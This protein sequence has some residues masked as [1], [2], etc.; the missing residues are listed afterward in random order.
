MN[1]SMPAANRVSGDILSGAA[2]FRSTSSNVADPT[3][4]GTVYA[5]LVTP[6]MP[7]APGMNTGTGS[8]SGNA[9][10]TTTSGGAASSVVVVPMSP[11]GER[12]TLTTP[13]VP[14]AA[15]GGTSGAAGGVLVIPTSPD[16]ERIALTT[17]G[18]GVVNNSSSGSALTSPNALVAVPNAQVITVS[19]GPNAA[20]NAAAGSSS[21]GGGNSIANMTLNTG[22]ASVDV[23]VPGSGAAAISSTTALDLPLFPDALNGSTVGG[24]SSNVAAPVGSGAPIGTTAPALSGAAGS[25]NSSSSSGG[26][27]GSFVAVLVGTDTVAPVANATSGVNSSGGATAVAGGGPVL[28][29]T[30]NA[31]AMGAGTMT[32]IPSS[33]STID[34]GVVSLGN[35]TAGAATGNETVGALNVRLNAT[36]PVY[37]TTRS[38]TSSWVQN[39]TATMVPMPTPW[40]SSTTSVWLTAPSAKAVAF[41]NPTITAVSLTNPADT[42]V[43]RPWTV[44]DAPITKALEVPQMSPAPATRPA[45]V[46]L[47]DLAINGT[48]GN[49][50]G[51]GNM[52]IGGQNMTMTRPAGGNITI[53]NV[54]LPLSN[55]SSNATANFKT[56]RANNVTFRFNEADLQFLKLG[57]EPTTIQRR[58]GEGTETLRDMFH[59]QFGLAGLVQ[60]AEIAWQQVSHCPRS[61]HF[62]LF[63]CQQYV[64]MKSSVR[65]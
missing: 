65:P 3:G 40:D 28:P 32:P 51:S 56:I 18:A 15:G 39:T 21:G 49:G 57:E 12:I 10:G 54:T 43:D 8:S 22:G 53:G 29:S 2:D 46:I 42:A 62:T 50:T 35:A 38:N 27:S 61:L 14:N 41:T 1:P 34:L 4:G 11:D 25:V 9:I 47:D 31:A 55:V 20:N 63:P 5:P 30:G 52:T 44:K 6:A 48:G 23:A 19:R 64:D 37:A 13:G 45:Y 58:R 17:P 36:M 60:V 24:N 33:N 26:D 59:A 16:G 7:N